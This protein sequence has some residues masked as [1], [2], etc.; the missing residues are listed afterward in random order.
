MHSKNSNDLSFSSEAVWKDKKR[1]YYY[2]TDINNNFHFSCPQMFGG[3]PEDGISPEELFL[4]SI[5]TCT[6]TTILHM[7]EKL[8]TNPLELNVKARGSLSTDGIGDYEFNPIRIII[9][10][11]GD[12]FLLQRAAELAQKY[13]LIGKSVNIT[14]NYEVNI[15]DNG[16]L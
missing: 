2:T 15:K 1:G 7:C 6:L 5:A 12:K 3:S 13:C 4:S 8:Q 11:K 9:D 16:N 14:L 10:M